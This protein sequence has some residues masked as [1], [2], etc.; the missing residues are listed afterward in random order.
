MRD[1]DE[2][3]LSFLLS[4]DGEVLSWIDSR[5][6]EGNGIAY[7]SHFLN[8]GGCSHFI[9]NKDPR[10]GRNQ[11]QSKNQNYNQRCNILTEKCHGKF[12]Q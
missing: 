5:G 2:L 1:F 3:L 12:T 7:G 8:W 10:T 11:G 6:I 9:G 4:A